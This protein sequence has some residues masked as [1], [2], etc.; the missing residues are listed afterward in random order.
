MGYATRFPMAPM[1]GLFVATIGIFILLGAFA[2]R[3]RLTLTYVGFAV[4]TI[5][6]VLGG[7]LAVGLPRPTSMQVGALVLAI[8]LEIIAF[9]V[10]MP[11]VRKAGERAIIVAT[12]VIVGCHFIVMLPAFGP[13]IGALGVLCALNAALLWKRASYRLEAAWLVDGAMKLAIGALLVATSP[14][15]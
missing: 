12:L 6:L 15:V 10:I 3:I 5:A 11:R 2:P 4:G 14:L 7:R 9:I 13:L 8:A 1:G